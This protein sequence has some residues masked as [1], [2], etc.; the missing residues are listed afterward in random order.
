MVVKDVVYF[1]ITKLFGYFL[2]RCF[3]VVV[4]VVAFLGGVECFEDLLLIPRALNHTS[5]RSGLKL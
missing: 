5:G 1:T 2:G 4:V 3:V